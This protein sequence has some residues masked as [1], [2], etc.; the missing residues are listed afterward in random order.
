M[1][2]AGIVA[3][4]AGGCGKQKENATP[5]SAR[6]IKSR[7]QL[8][9]IGLPERAP[10]Q[11]NYE[12]PSAEEI[13]V[14]VDRARDHMKVN[15][16]YKALDD[17]MDSGSQFVAG[18]SYVF[19]YDYSGK[20]LADWAEPGVIGKNLSASDGAEGAFFA[21]AAQAARQGGGWVSTNWRVPGGSLN[22]PKQ[23][24]VR[25]VDGKY[26]IGSGMYQ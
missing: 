5:T 25:D 1:G 20:C 13:R 16:E 14:L 2:L 24:Y 9:E 18:K 3:V 8:P 11:I 15:G 21:Q 17:F 12:N 22:R 23:C 7:T 19:V 26:L 4:A 10:H 6:V